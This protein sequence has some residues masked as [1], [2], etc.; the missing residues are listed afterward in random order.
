MDLATR[1]EAELELRRRLAEIDGMPLVNFVQ[2]INPSYERPHHLSP[3]LDEVERAFHE[4]VEACFSAPPQVGKSE[5]LFSAFA[6]FIA[7]NPTKKNAY[8]SYSATIAERKSRTILE[9]AKRARAHIDPLCQSSGYWKTVE[10]GSV[11]AAGIGGPLT[12]EGIDGWIVIDDPHKSRAEAESPVRREAVH[13]W[14]TSIQ[15]RLHPGSSTF[16]NHH[17]WHEDDLIGRQSDP[18]GDAPMKLINLPALALDGT[19][20]WESMRP[21]AWWE[22]KRA[23]S[24]YDWESLFQGNPR[25]KGSKVFRDAH[26]YD[27]LPPGGYRVAIGVDCAYSENKKSDY[28]VGLA[29]AAYDI[30]DTTG[31]IVD[32]QYYVLLVHRVQIDSPAFS[33]I[34]NGMSVAWPGSPMWWYMA[35]PEKGVAQH[36]RNEGARMLRAIPATVDK[37]I[38]AQPVAA[39]WNRGKIFVPRDAPWVAELL[40]EV[41]G[42][43]GVKDLHDD[44]VDALAA[45]FD[46]LVAGGGQTID[47]KVSGPRQNRSLGGF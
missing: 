31:R 9:Y 47:V 16:I 22:A 4:P 38:R 5:A 24:D 8:I 21:A 13:S 29:L 25:P 12:G 39:A 20:L 41:L 26:L 17:R 27:E 28:S 6:R 46:A 33:K 43:T 15:G 10:G 32:T 40:K 1:A 7:R 11:I 23:K 3:I 30:R 35:G 36:I 37:L 34:L 2:H 19:Y 42:F 18:D 44:Q 14:F 45:A